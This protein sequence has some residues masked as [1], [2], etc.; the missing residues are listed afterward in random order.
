MAMASIGQRLWKRLSLQV[1]ARSVFLSVSIVKI[2]EESNFAEQPYSTLL[3]QDQVGSKL[4]DVPVKFS[5]HS[6]CK[7][8]RVCVCV[9]RK[10]SLFDFFHYAVHKLRAACV[11]VRVK[12]I[13]NKTAI[14]VGVSASCGRSTPPSIQR[15]SKQRDEGPQGDL[16]QRHKVSF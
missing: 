1:F 5:E 6:C 14:V 8:L 9:C 13:V 10:C 3:D 16:N 4:T 7:S 11:V 15:Y 2:G 12:P